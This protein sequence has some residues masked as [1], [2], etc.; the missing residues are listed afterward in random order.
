MHGLFRDGEDWVRVRYD[1][2]RELDMLKAS[3]LKLKLQPPFDEL[4]LVADGAGL[5]PYKNEGALASDGSG[6]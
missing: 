3:Y 4:P 5:G 2:G 1:N 6:T